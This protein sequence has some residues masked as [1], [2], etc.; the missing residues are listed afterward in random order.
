MP[1]I[2]AQPLLD[3][4]E[5]KGGIDALPTITGMP[6]PDPTSGQVPVLRT[7]EE[8]AHL[9]YIHTFVKR[10]R[11]QGRLTFGAV[12]DFC[13]TALGCHPFEV[14]GAAWFQYLATEVKS[15]ER[16]GWRWKNKDEEAAA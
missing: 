3:Y 16:N 9:T 13:I 11:A 15:D 1:Y 5:K 4:I 10:A 7:R 6:V 12:D 8:K 14:Y 2:P